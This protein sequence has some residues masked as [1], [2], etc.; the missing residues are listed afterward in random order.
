MLALH[1]GTVVTRDEIVD[2]LWERAPDSAVNI[3]HKHICVLRGLLGPGHSPVS[4]Q[5]LAW[6]AGGYELRVSPSAVDAAV[7]ERQR[8]QARRARAAG[9]LPHAVAQLSNGLALWQSSSALAG[10]AGPWAL[11]VRRELLE[12]KLVA[13]EE[14]A[15]M[16]LQLGRPAELTSELTGLVGSH[17]LREGL[18]HRLMLAY[19]H[20]GH[21][22]QAQQA[23][24]TICR[25][26]ADELGTEP[27]P[28]LRRLYQQIILQ[29][30]R[31][32]PP[33]APT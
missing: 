7:F 22:A 33:P 8:A 19:Y 23:Y 31:L 21:L 32:D 11:A 10:L 29:D 27:G 15:D 25:V 20:S 9:D 3:V 1:A 18:W 2:A 24:Q 26:L 5:V 6:V 14:R 17:P 30:L 4:G 12:A 28:A 13:A 16:L